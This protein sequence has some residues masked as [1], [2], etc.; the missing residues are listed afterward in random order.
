M[1]CAALFPPFT[2]RRSGSTR[3]RQVL[4]SQSGA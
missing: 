4:D 1:A 2:N 3:T